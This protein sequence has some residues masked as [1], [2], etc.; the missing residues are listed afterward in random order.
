[1][2]L[3]YT[4]L[5]SI[6]CYSFGNAQVPNYPAITGLTFQNHSLT[7]TSVVPASGQSQPLSTQPT[8]TDH[9]IS[10]NS[11]LDAENQIYYYVSSFPARL[12]GFDL[13]SGQ[14]VRNY[15]LPRDSLTTYPLSAIQYHPK[16]SLIYGIRQ[17][18]NGLFFVSFDPTNGQ[19]TTISNQPIA[20]AI[21]HAGDATIDTATHTFYLPWGTRNSM[22]AAIDITTGQAQTVMVNDPLTNVHTI[23][24][25]LN[26]QFNHTDGFIYGLHFSTGALRFVKMDPSTGQVSLVSNGPISGDMFQVG[27]CTFDEQNQ[28][29]YYTRV[30]WGQSE[31]VAVDVPTGQVLAA[32]MIQAPN[33]HASFVNPEFNPLAQ[34]AARFLTSLDC[35]KGEVA[36][37]NQSL[38]NQFEW[39]FGDGTTST[40]IHPKH[41]YAQPGTYQVTLKAHAHQQTNVYTQSV[42][43]QPPLDI[44]IAGPD[45]FMVGERA[46]LSITSGMDSY[47]W[48]SGHQNTSSIFLTHGGTYTVTVT[49]QG[50]TTTASKQVRNVLPFEMDKSR[51]LTT[52]Y[53]KEFSSDLTLSNPSSKLLTYVVHMTNPG[54]FPSTIIARHPTTTGD[55]TISQ[56]HNNTYQLRLP[57][58]SSG[59]LHANWYAPASGVG[60]ISMIM[61]HPF[62]GQME[63]VQF[64]GIAKVLTSTSQPNQLKELIAY[65]NPVRAG[66]SIQWSLDLPDNG[67]ILDVQG[68]LIGQVSQGER[69]TRM[70]DSP[71]MYFIQLNNGDRFTFTVIR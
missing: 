16:D 40:A 23:A 56:Q 7:P 26:V 21:H 62:G 2:R 67:R 5:F 12:Y 61:Q 24:R 1:M 39:D 4:F 64:I 11:T 58:F 57:S 69:E 32:P 37:G 42:D 34:P 47:Q 71:G 52:S 51:V 41:Q 66:R 45:S 15:L 9:F 49:H 27:N 70:P 50:C 68:R 43:V 55:I 10:G 22:L 63:E 30:P 20:Q 8:S 44:N 29:Y 18:S 17:Q 13:V 25:I 28:V 65:P 19:L 6:L 53:E 36:F 14:L 31:L 38:G 46:T 33:S 54:H 35:D 59:V 3:F 48:N 60:R